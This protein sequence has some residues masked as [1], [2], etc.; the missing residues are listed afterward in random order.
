MAPTTYTFTL[1]YSSSGLGDFDICGNLVVNNNVVTSLQTTTITAALISPS[2]KDISNCLITSS[3]VPASASMSDGTTIS[4][5]VTANTDSNNYT[6]TITSTTGTPTTNTIKFDNVFSPLSTD[7]ILFYIQTND[8]F[9]QNYF[10]RIRNASDRSFTTREV[11]NV[12]V[13]MYSEN[14]AILG[15]GGTFPGTFS[16]E[17][18]TVTTP[19]QICMPAGTVV[20]TDQG[21]FNIET[22][23][24]NTHTI[25]G[26]RLVGVSK[27]ISPDNR[28]VLF[29]KNALG[30]NVPE[31]DTYL[32][33]AHKVC[34]G[35]E[36]V[37]ADKVL[38][39]S[40]NNPLIVAARLNKGEVLYNVLLETYHVMTVNNMQVETLHP[41]HS[42]ARLYQQQQEQRQ[43]TT[44]F[45]NNNGTWF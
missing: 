30:P 25:D 43:N 4:Y 10:I 31:M 13:A 5:S 14:G 17:L 11:S 6:L 20:Q 7:G 28:L 33:P 15:G 2:F 39:R 36:M 8:T 34:L 12:S 29:K 37:E 16:Y 3:N 44:F 45:T 18:D 19:D 38:R 41:S 32:T 26:L 21:W 24:V 27:T 42:I 1:S 22:L 40:R 9:S 23:N 35:E